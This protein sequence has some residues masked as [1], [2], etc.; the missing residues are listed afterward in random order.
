MMCGSTINSLIDLFSVSDA[1]DYNQDLFFDDTK[2]Y[3]LIP[4]S[5]TEF[6]AKFTFEWLDIVFQLSRIGREKENLLFNSLLNNEV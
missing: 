2:Y 1:N 3:P 6:P 4:N 5:Q